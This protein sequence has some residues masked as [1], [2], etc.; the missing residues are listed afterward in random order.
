MSDGPKNVRLFERNFAREVFSN[1][2]SFFFG[3][4]GP[5]SLFILILFY[6]F[7]FN[8]HLLVFLFNFKIFCFNLFFLSSLFIIVVFYL[9][10]FLFILICSLYPFLLFH[11]YLFLSQIIMSNKWSKF[12]KR[13]RCLMFCFFPQMQP[14]L[15]PNAEFFCILNKP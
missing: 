13:T 4:S 6:Y 8:F 15:I 12:N 5:S 11:F 3:P 1:T 2:S 14:V 7:I 9:I 10:L